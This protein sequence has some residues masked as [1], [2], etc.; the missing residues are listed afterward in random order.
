MKPGGGPLTLIVAYQRP[1]FSTWAVSAKMHHRVPVSF[2]AFHEA[3][4]RKISDRRSGEFP[5]QEGTTGRLF[6][7]LNYTAV[8]YVIATIMPLHCEHKKRVV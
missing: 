3:F 2:A 5:T 6:A 4:P 7:C 8:M 1:P